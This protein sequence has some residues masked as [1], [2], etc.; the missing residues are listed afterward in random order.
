MAPKSRATARC[1]YS[2]RSSFRPFAFFEGHR[3]AGGAFERH[4][5]GFSLQSFGGLRTN[6][7][8]PGSPDDNLPRRPHQEKL[9]PGNRHRRPKLRPSTCIP[10]QPPKANPVPWPFLIYYSPCLFFLDCFAECTS[11]FWYTHASCVFTVETSMT[12]LCDFRW[13]LLVC[14][15][16]STSSSLC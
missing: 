3:I 8:S 14:K 11:S 6:S 16:R 15:R 2:L 1:R 4:E 5:T 7:H 12:M 13:L 9:L 10:F